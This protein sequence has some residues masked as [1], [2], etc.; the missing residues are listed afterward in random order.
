M[1]ATVAASGNPV[2]VPVTDPQAVSD[3]AAEV[4]DDYFKIEREDPVRVIGNMLT[5][6]SISTYP[7]VSPTILEPWRVDTASIDQRVE[8]TLQTYRRR[9]IVKIIPAE[10]GHWIEVQVPMELADMPQPDRASSGAAT[11]RYD[12]GFSRVENPIGGEAPLQ[13]WIPKGRDALLEQRI[14]GQMQF[15]AQEVQGI[16]R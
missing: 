9:A 10:N 3:M 11:F 1:P 7:A 16:P 15:R 13:G 5:E 2:F 12:S 4:V 6:G 8:N 14:L